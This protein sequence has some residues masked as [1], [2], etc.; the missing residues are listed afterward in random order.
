MLPLL[1]LVLLLLLLPAALR[2]ARSCCLWVRISAHLPRSMPPLLAALVL[3]QLDQATWRLWLRAVH[4]W[5]HCCSLWLAALGLPV[6]LCAIIGLH[7]Q[8]HHVPAHAE[9]WCLLLIQVSHLGHAGAYM[10][11]CR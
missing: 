10:R 2:Q 8:L 7:L 9:A 6:G 5:Y 3:V 1:L 4:C 11:T